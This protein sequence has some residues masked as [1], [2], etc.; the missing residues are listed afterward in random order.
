MKVAAIFASPR[1]NG[2]SAQMLQTALEEFPEHA[3]IH[4]IYLADL[5]FSPCCATRDCLQTGECPIEDD[6]QKIYHDL[7]WADIILFATGSQ[8]G[9]VTADLKALIER[10]WPLRGELKNKIG[11]YVVS[12]RRYAESTINTLHA[13]MLRH[14]MILGNS[15]AIG[16][17][18]DE[19]D[20]QNDPLAIED[21]RKT[22]KRLVEL[23]QLIYGMDEDL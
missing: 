4:H 14:Q 19:G 6:M 12:A 9:D 16:Y 13:F 3:E 8:F 17:G 7:R 18:F 5:D 20:I 11:G 15:G 1:K 2:N 23:Y 21:S 10:T 22:G